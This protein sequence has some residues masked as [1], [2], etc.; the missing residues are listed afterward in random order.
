VPK[1]EK[2]QRLE[3]ALALIKALWT[4]QPVDF[5]GRF[6]QLKNARISV[7][8]IQEPRP[9]I[10]MAA[11]GDKAVVRAAHLAD[12]WLV[13]PRPSLATL[14][15]QLA[16]Y[17]GALSEAEKDFPAEFPIIR[18][19]YVGETD[20]E[21]FEEARP[22]IEAKY[23]T[24]TSWGPQKLVPET[25]TQPL[26]ELAA[27]RFIIGSPSHCIDEL[28]RYSRELGAS[29]FI[30]RMGWPGMKHS[31]IMNSIKTFGERVIPYFKG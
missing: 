7:K 26:A 21:A 19:T 31:S 3:E 1:A 23:Q 16:L 17:R 2:A 5:Q 30:L 15:R 10:W 20:E 4:G 13:D 22:Y 11:T 9:P 25:L 27:D 8:P 6:F 24:Y 14:S 29:H 18:E 28:M 12:A